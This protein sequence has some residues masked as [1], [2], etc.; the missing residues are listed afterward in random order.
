MTTS[1]FRIYAVIAFV[2]LLSWGLVKL[3]EPD[4]KKV[5]VIA[6]NNIDYFS[7]GYSKREM[8]DS[9]IPK[10]QLVAERMTHYQGDGTTHL[11]RPVMTLYNGSIAP[12]LIEAET[13]ILLA[14]GDNLLLNGVVAINREGGKGIKPLKIN[15]S[16]LR[17]N[18]P[19][20][21]AETD[22][23]TEIVSTA[24]RTIGT[25]MEVT[26]VEPI[27]L[28]LLSRVKGRYEVK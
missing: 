21:Y 7:I 11:V 24:N 19:S 9:G 17:V 16:D 6:K 8:D 22:N 23:W 10:N 13:G 20:N 25:G 15:T 2:A 5:H 12:W 14:D 4:E 1:Q 26:F 18:L 28:K 3:T 27:H